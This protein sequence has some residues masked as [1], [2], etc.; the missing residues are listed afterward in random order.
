MTLY[1]DMQRSCKQG[2]SEL[3]HPPEFESSE[4]R[5]E[6]EI[7]NICIYFYNLP[8]NLKTE[9]RLCYV[10][11]SVADLHVATSTTHM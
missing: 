9:R 5:Y 8:L 3:H 1:Y 7:D 11:M 6:G 10:T 2:L 4:K